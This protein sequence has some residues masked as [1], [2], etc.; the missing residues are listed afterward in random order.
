MLTKIN[1]P[2][3][4]I[5][6]FNVFLFILLMINYNR[7]AIWD[8]RFFRYN[9]FLF[10]KEGLTAKFLT[11]MRIQ[12][13]GPLYQLIHA[14]FYKLTEYDLS[15][16][17]LVNFG[18]FLFVQFM[19]YQILQLFTIKRKEI[20]LLIFLALPGVFVTSIL[21]M[22]QMPTYTMLSVFIYFFIK[23]LKTTDKALKPAP[24]HI[25]IGVVCGVFLG[26]AIIGR[27]QFL[28]LLPGLVIL[29]FIRRKSDYAYFL[30]PAIIASSMIYLPVFLTWK[31]IVPPKVGF[32]ET[33]IGNLNYRNLFICSVYL[34]LI[35]F[36]VFK[37]SL[38]VFKPIIK[39]WKVSIAS[40]LL[41]A[42]INIFITKYS[43][44]ND[45]LIR[46]VGN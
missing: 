11:D 20:Y 39:Y 33:G 22:T 34:V 7:P 16:T 23:Y 2:L 1:K 10:Q 17:R 45:T 9:L 8:E 41:L 26:L 46:L 37:K 15:K 43:Y 36:L 31:G 27:V 28:M 42:A 24:F 13:P 12:A 40:F 38:T 25:L 5:F 14:L 35:N 3:L 29:L 6:L 19:V 4:I 44:P 30:L 32:V 18:L 21:A